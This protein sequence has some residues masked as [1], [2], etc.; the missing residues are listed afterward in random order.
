MKQDL[1]CAIE[2]ND[3]EIAHCAVRVQSPGVELVSVHVAET[4]EVAQAVDKSSVAHRPA[5]IG[6]YGFFV[7]G[8]VGS[9]INNANFVQPKARVVVEYVE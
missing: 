3:G 9:H 2:P 1:D 8:L 4:D 5:A 7:I 6:E